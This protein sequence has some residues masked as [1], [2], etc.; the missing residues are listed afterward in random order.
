M[1]RLKRGET[2]FINMRPTEDHF[3]EW[4]DE[5]SAPRSALLIEDSEEERQLILRLSAPFNIRWSVASN[6][7]EALEEVRKKVLENSRFQ[8]IILDLNLCGPPQ[9]AELF[10]MIKS[11][12]PVCPILV[13]SGYITNEAIIQITKAGFAMFAQKPVVFD[14]NFFEQLFSALNIPRKGPERETKQCADFP[15]I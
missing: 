12:C 3:K 5:V 8:L 9:E 1:S 4:L 14:S 10:R 7:A 11:V 13:L 15:T 6:G 2:E